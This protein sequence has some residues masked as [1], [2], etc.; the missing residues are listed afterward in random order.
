VD[1]LFEQTGVMRVD[2][3]EELFDVAMALSHQPIPRGNRVVVVTNAGGPGILAT[4][5]LINNG[6]E[7]PPLAPSSVKT[8]KKFLSSDASFSNPMD[9]VAGAGAAEYHKTLEVVQAHK[10]YDTILTLFV[11]PVTSDELEVARNIRRALTDTDKTVLACFMGLGES[12]P[13]KDYLNN[14]GIP[15]YQFPEAAAKALAIIN[16]Y[17]EWLKKPKGKLRTFKV[18]SDKVRAIVERNTAAGNRA[19]VGD[20]AMDILKAYGIQ[21]AG[22]EYAFSGQE[23][24]SVANKIGYPVVM[25]VNTPPVL[26]KT[27]IGAV[28]VDLRSDAEA[29]KAF[30]ELRA[31]VGEI[32]KG[33]KFSVVVQQ[34]V[35]GSAETV[36][37]MTTIPSFGPLIMIGLGGI[38]VEVMKDVAFR[39]SP[40]TEQAARDMIKSLKSYCLLT[41]FRGAPPVDLGIIEETLLRVSQLVRDFDCFLE[42]D[43]NPF[44][45]SQNR[46]QCKAVD[47]RFIVRAAG[48]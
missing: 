8:L 17:R 12:T 7:M 32:K 37:G 34:M 33:E 21:V 31:R 14:H 13:G 48:S 19:I 3:M 22:Y 40:L 45:V 24:V 43:I 38:Y 29:R 18:D 36:I 26:H 28:M 41:G 23:A 25:K 35:S 11:P 39:I 42:I 6:M 20:D 44:I 9:M 10:R 4:D 5:A 15:V 27:E 1:A 46:N 16:G 2:S 47:V 30:R